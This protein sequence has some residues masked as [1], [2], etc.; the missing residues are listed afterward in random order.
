MVAFVVTVDV[1]DVATE[2]VAI[3]FDTKAGTAVVE[4]AEAAVDEGVEE[5][6]G[7]TD[8]VVGDLTVAEAALV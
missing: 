2:A 7:T 5:G 8:T 4:D 3:D 6:E 1:G